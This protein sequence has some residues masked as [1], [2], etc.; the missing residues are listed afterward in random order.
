MK[1]ITVIKLALDLVM[2]ILFS[3]LFNKSVF[4]GLNFHELIGLIIGF[5][6]LMHI[7]LNIKWIRKVSVSIFTKKNSIKNKNRIY[8]KYSTINR[9]CYNNNKW[10]GNFKSVNS[11]TWL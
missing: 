3:L 6:V 4:S 1:K 7:I 5:V 9:Y 11:W 10:N 8:I 2:A